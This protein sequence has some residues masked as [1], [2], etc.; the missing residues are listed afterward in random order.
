MPGAQ[1]YLA[2]GLYHHNSPNLPHFK[3]SLWPEFRRWC[4]WDQVVE[5]HQRFGKLDWEPHEPFTIVF[6]N[7]TTLHCAGTEKPGSLEGPNLNFVYFDEARHHP[8]DKVLKVVDGRVRIPGP[9]GEPPQIWLTTTPAMNWLYT[10]F[11]PI[12]PEGDP[13]ESF[14]RNSRVITLS[15][16]ENEINTFDGFSENRSQ[17]LTEK[18]ARVLLDAEWEDLTE[19]QPFLPDMI[20]WDNCRED[21]PPLTRN[22]QLVIALD[23]ATG[24]TVTSSDCF[25]IVGVTRHPD[26]RRRETDVAI[27]YSKVWQVK[28]GKKLDYQGDEYNPGPERELLRLCGYVYEGDSIVYKPGLGFNVVVIVYD[29]KELH[30]MA[31][32]LYRAG[33]GWFKEFGQGAQ[34][35]ESDRQLLDLIQQRRLAHNGDA[36]LRK[37]IQNADR[38]TDDSGGALRIVKRTD[39]Q[40][41][42]LAVDTSMACYEALRLNI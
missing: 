8:D 34:R 40:K 6:K 11:G 10:Y 19:G 21:I 12:D 36:E 25:A 14:K 3:R 26:P 15:T 5:G 17:S 30:D 18:E 23:A 1:H 27:R 22:E 4:P 16:K 37:H 7:N 42:D 28:P 2:H 35:N 33:V 38:K 29:P 24:R 32:R 39:S 13:Y 31:M 20:W 9:K 41:I